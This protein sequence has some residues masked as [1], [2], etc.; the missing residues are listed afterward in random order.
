MA[1]SPGLMELDELLN[2]LAALYQFRSLDERTY[3][4]LTVSQSYSLRILYFQGPRT[5]GQLATDLGVKVSTLTGIVD[6]LAARGLVE[7]ASH[8][9]DRRSVR[10]ALTARGRKS[11][12]DAHDAFLSHLGPLL[13]G[14]SKAELQHI[15][16]FLSGA[17]DV[18]RGWRDNPKKVRHGKPNPTRK[19]GG[20]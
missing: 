4:A 7:R 16:D 2:Q 9:D 5:M 15:L 8:P 10:V 20:R 13:G 17:L 6:Q 18:I 19:R 1:V 11:Y 14:Q 12:R 3:A